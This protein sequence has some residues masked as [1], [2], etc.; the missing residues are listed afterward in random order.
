MHELMPHE[1]LVKDA[2]EQSRTIQAVA[3]V[4]VCTPKLDAKSLFAENTIQLG[5]KELHLEQTR[6][7]SPQWLT[8]SPQSAV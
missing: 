3:I 1:L 8:L 5:H 6:K 7:F 4:L 2:P